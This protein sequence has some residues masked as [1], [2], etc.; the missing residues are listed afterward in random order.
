M[1]DKNLAGIPVRDNL[2]NLLPPRMK[3]ERKKKKIN[4]IVKNVLN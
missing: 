1:N 3:R 2:T 4:A